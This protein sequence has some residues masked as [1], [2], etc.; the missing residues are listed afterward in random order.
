VARRGGRGHEIGDGGA[1]V[2]IEEGKDALYEGQR[3]AD[4]VD[5]LLNAGGK[6]GTG[7]K[8]GDSGL[9]WWQAATEGDRLVGLGRDGG[10]CVGRLGWERGRQSR[11]GGQG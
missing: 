8:L 3:C 5:N 10:A 1:D 9:G 6:V 7:R 2:A 11:A 4:G